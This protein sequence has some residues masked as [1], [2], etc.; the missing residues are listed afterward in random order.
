MVD[1]LADSSSDA[2]PATSPHFW[3]RAWKDINFLGHKGVPVV[4]I[5]A[6]DGA[7]WDALGQDGRAAALRLLGGAQ[8]R[9]PA[10]HSGGLWLSRSL[11]ELV[12]EAEASSSRASR[13]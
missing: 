5:S 12:R 3:S 11:E 1:E 10:Y 9:V 7:L 4:G 2:T 8:D 6:L 13:R